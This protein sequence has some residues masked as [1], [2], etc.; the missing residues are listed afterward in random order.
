MFQRILILC[1]GNI[2]RSPV[3]AAML[4]ARLHGK[5]IE[6]AGLNALEGQGVEPT[7]R[8]L[9]EA[10]GLN[11]SAHQA[12]QVSLET[13]FK[14]DLVLVMSDG[15]RLAVGQ[16]APSVLGKTMLFGRWLDGGQGREIP[17]PY[18]KSDEAFRQVHQLLREAADSWV[19]KL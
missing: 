1:T 16:M 7:A 13:L 5:Q 9:A 2:C 10:E 3:A 17:D 12:R 15:Q 14:A 6:S 18:R 19:G 4:E 11:V 8:L